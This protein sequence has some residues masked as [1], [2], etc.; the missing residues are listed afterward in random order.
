MIEYTCPCCDKSQ[1]IP[2][3]AAGQSGYCQH[4]NFPI[5]I[6][7]KKRAP[8]KRNRIV[9]MLNSPISIPGKTRVL[10]M[11][12]R[13][14]EILA[15]RLL[16]RIGQVGHRI[17][18]VGACVLGALVLLLLVGGLYVNIIEPEVFRARSWWQYRPLAEHAQELWTNAPVSP[19]QALRTLTAGLRTFGS[20]QSWQDGADKVLPGKLVVVTINKNGHGNHEIVWD[21]LGGLG[22]ELVAQGFKRSP[23][24]GGHQEIR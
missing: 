13:I 24:R 18:Q 14:Q 7:E 23:C 10:R 21:L 15:S 6:P 16:H 17:G 1:S 3:Q 11:R 8:R 9:V 2:D 5:S 20:W 4:C 12:D 19:I 22:E